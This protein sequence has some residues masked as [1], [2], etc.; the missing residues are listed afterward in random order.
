MQI[1][2]LTNLRAGRVSAAARGIREVLGGRRDVLH[3]ETHDAGMVEQAL[4][5]F[6]QEETDLLVLCGGDGTLQRALTRILGDPESSWRPMLAPLRGGR[7]NTSAMAMGVQRHPGK[8]LARVLEAARAGRLDALVDERA[9]LRAD[10]AGDGVQ[11]GMFFG[12]GILYDAIRS[13]HDRF[14]EGPAQGLLGAAVTTS[15]LIGRGMLG[16]YGGVLS[17]QKM[18]VALDGVPL[19]PREYLIA[20]ATTLDR[21]FLRIRPFWGQE[22]GPVRF[23]TIAP[24]VGGLKNVVRVLSGQA[25]TVDNPGFVSRNVDS[26]ALHLDGGTTVDGELYEPEPA[27]IVRLSAE[28]RVRFVCG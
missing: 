17:P 1:G 25:P 2:V 3:L 16:R 28:D 20:M 5:V 6:E 8:S 7:T 13:T 15:A 21:L 18:Q 11:Y 23:T 10:L 22:S 9:V 27:R 19:E 26:V 24:G 12:S 14:P 4:G